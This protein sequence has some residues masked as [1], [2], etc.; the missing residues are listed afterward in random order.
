MY[1]LFAPFLLFVKVV[2]AREEPSIVSEAKKP[3][4]FKTRIKISMIQEAG[5]T[6]DVYLFENSGDFINVSSSGGGGP[7]HICH[8]GQQTH[9]S[10]FWTSTSFRFF[11]PNAN[12]VSEF[13]TTVGP[14]VTYLKAEAQKAK[15]IF[16]IPFGQKLSLL[17]KTHIRT[18]PFSQTCIE[19]K[20]VAPDTVAT[21]EVRRIDFYL[22]LATLLGFSLFLLSHR[23]SHSPLVFYIF[24]VVCGVSLSLLVLVYLVHRKAGVGGLHWL[25][26]G[27]SV[28]LSLI[29][30]LWHSAMAHAQ[31]HTWLA[32]YVATSGILTFCLLYRLGTPHPRTLDLVQWGLRAGGLAVIFFSSYQQESS[33][34]L[35]LVL[36][37]WLSVPAW[38]KAKANT[39]VR[40]KLFSKQ[41]KLLSEEEYDRQSL[42]ETRKAL[43]E[44]RRYCASSAS[45]PWRT[46]SSLRDPRRFA[47]FMSG[48]PHVTEGEVLEYSTW[49]SDTSSLEETRNRDEAE[50]DLTDD[51]SD[52]AVNS[53][54]DAYQ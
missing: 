52:E 24:G 41:I 23:L 51:D 37:G 30:Y 11:L 2:G 33:L 1:S 21:L 34:C 50:A 13:E 43:E 27:Y 25:V 36:L 44:L 46:V 54:F 40:R 12:V 49:D 38:L 29:V 32:G 48:S 20:P 39:A 53:S 22:F 28:S 6:H 5:I 31:L 45:K 16:Q 19:F 15:S 35:V 8:V 3:N 7:V 26:A 17:S 18:S 10:K 9:L 14:N 47:D 4:V 42:E